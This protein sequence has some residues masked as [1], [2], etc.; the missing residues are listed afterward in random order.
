MACRIPLSYAQN[1]ITATV[2]RHYFS[3]TEIS[4]QGAPTLKVEYPR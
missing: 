1:L 3:S 4:V 2:I